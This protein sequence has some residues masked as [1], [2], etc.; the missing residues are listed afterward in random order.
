[1]WAVEKY[2][3]NWDGYAGS[4]DPSH[5]LPNNY[6]L[7]SDSAGTFTMLPWGLDQ[8]WLPQMHLAFDGPANGTLF[9]HCLAD[10][11]CAELY[12]SAL[13]DVLDALPGLDLDKTAAD[14]A[15]LLAPYQE[16]EERDSLREEFDMNRVATAVTET[17]D[18][19]AGRPAEA[20]AF[21]RPPPPSGQ[22]PA[23]GPKTTESTPVVPVVPPAGGSVPPS[24]RPLGIGKPSFAGGFITTRL[25]LPGAGRV[26]LRA[27]STVRGRVRTA[28][29]TQAARAASASLTLRCRLSADA[30]R[31]LRAGKLHLTLR[32]WFIP[33]RGTAEMAL[34]RLTL[35]RTR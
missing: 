23:S 19:A 13:Q 5:F 28:C 26:S 12:R 17:R 2:V 6:F 10:A 16:R 32:H 11:S 15:A 21:L 8:T 4:T 3:G 20:D 35:P 9:Q 22:P 30:R 27:F 34:R 31:R 1:M 25:V 29:F 33:A 7:H 18:F 14:A 24:L